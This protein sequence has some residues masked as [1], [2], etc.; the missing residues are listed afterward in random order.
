MLAERGLPRQRAR[1]GARIRVLK[2]SWDRL[3]KGLGWQFLE[4]L[5]LP[6]AA[7]RISTGEMSRL[8]VNFTCCRMVLSRAAHEA[9]RIVRGFLIRKIHTLFGFSV[10]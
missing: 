9:S 5:I 7:G 3:E 2:I 4:A 8:Q 6:N 1:D 10:Q